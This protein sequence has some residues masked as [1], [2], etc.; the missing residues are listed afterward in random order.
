MSANDGD[1]SN[2]A[3]SRKALGAS[4]A[5]TIGSSLDGGQKGCSRWACRDGV[6]VSDRTLI[7]ESLLLEGLEGVV[8]RKDVGVEEMSVVL[9]GDDGGQNFAGIGGG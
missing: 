5:S 8:G 1:G 9:G 2:G 6:G 3:L 7:D 4:V